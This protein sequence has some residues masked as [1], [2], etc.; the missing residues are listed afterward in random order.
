MKYI[1]DWITFKSEKINEDVTILTSID[2]LN[3]KLKSEFAGC[4]LIAYLITKDL[5]E[6]RV[7]VNIKKL[8]FNPN[9]KS[10]YKSFKKKVEK[11]VTSFNLEFKDLY[12]SP[13]YAEKIKK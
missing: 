8:N 6:E 13:A 11:I 7:I 12:I 1:N 4:K 9:D 10:E 3:T 5:N 2:A